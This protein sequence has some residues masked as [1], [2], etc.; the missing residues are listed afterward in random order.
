M[1]PLHQRV[2]FET[3]AA[4][5]LP[6]RFYKRN[7]NNNVITSPRFLSSRS[8]SSSSFSLPLPPSPTSSLGALVLHSCHSPVTLR[9]VSPSSHRADIT[10]RELQRLASISIES[11]FFHEQRD[12]CTRRPGDKTRFLLLAVLIRVPIRVSCV[13]TET[14]L[15]IAVVSIIVPVPWPH[16]DGISLRIRAPRWNARFLPRVLMK[17]DVNRRDATI[18]SRATITNAHRE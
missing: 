15:P 13:C 7:A 12:P 14:C 5:S 3:I 6:P 16:D 10:H 2:R 1:F 4:T 11:N 9:L 17:Y 18:A 8:S